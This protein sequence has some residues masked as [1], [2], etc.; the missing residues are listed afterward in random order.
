M[1]KV[2]LSLYCFSFTASL[3]FYSVASTKFDFMRL[4]FYYFGLL[5][6][7]YYL[8]LLCWKWKKERQR[9]TWCNE[10]KSS[11]RF[12]ILTSFCYVFLHPKRN[13]RKISFFQRLM[14]CH[15]NLCLLNPI[16][17]ELLLLQSRC[18]WLW[19]DTWL[20]R[21]GFAHTIERIAHVIFIT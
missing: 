15:I 6:V 19:D 1:N 18:T 14:K 2:R 17:I 10:P 9:K 8:Y 5:F 20:L 7:C 4:D 21:K 3:V 16:L 12:R 11:K 13:N